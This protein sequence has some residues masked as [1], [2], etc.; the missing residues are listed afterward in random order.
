MYYCLN[1]EYLLRGWEKLQTGIVRK[2]TGQT[3][4]L[5]P[6]F[7]SKIRTMRGLMFEGSPFL[8]PEEHEYMSQLVKEGIVY[9]SETA[10]PYTPEQEY[11]LYPNR[12]LRMIHWAITGHCNCRCRHCYMSAPTGKIPEYSTE[13][14]MEIIDQMEAAGV[15]MVSL[16]GG[17][18]LVRR[19]FIKLITRLTEAGIKIN[20]IMSN[21]ILVNEELLDA[22][23]EL[24]QK[25]EFNMS[26][27]GIG[28]HDWL[29]GVDGVE[30]AVIRAFKLC[31]DRGFPTGA[32]YCLHRGNMDVFRESVKLLGELGCRSLK[33]NTLKAEGEGTGIVEYTI[34]LKEEYQFYMDYLPQYFEDG[35]PVDLMLSGMFMKTQKGE[36]IIP[37]AK[38]PEDKDCSDY[39]LCGHARNVM[40]ITADGYIVPCIP[41]GS[42]E[43]GRNHFPNIHDTTIGEA[44]HDSSYMEFINTRLSTYF[45][46]NPECAVCEYRN[47]CAGGC[48]GTAASSGDLLG[49]DE[50]DC[51]LF[52]GGWFDKVL[53]FLEDRVGVKAGEKD[54]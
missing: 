49:K 4:F 26:F 6:S 50:R 22:L 38:L 17:E 21:G 48:R 32:E 12:Y 53:A 34:P 37:A 16:T 46:H 29:R 30:E 2:G 13:K 27:D 20:T 8:T 52:L 10:V 45:E 11:R 40:H 44:L 18:A 1:E 28:R 5:Q 51:E 36:Y 23:D 14:C 9:L 54:L 15:Q 3:F 41:I 33:V 19:D 24:G 35:E 7:Y 43:N 31:R 47:R 42:V 25:P 39:C